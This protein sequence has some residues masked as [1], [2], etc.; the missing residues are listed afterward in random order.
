MK[1][2]GLTII[3]TGILESERAWSRIQA[4]DLRTVISELRGQLDENRQQYE[5][6][7]RENVRI[8][9]EAHGRECDLKHE[10]ARLNEQNAS[11]QARI[12][13]LTSPVTAE[14]C[15]QAVENAA[16]RKKEL[17]DEQA[18]LARELARKARARKRINEEEEGE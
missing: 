9:T 5:A 10:L 7:L 13:D 2:F 3:R 16:R 15:I 8:S 17:A 18:A 11:L 14:E 4:D 12:R 1:L 6:A